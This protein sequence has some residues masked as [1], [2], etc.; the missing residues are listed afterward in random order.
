MNRIL[1]IILLA[2]SVWVVLGFIRPQF[3]ETEV[4]KGLIEERKQT[5]NDAERVI[6]R[7]DQI[8]ADYASV[9]DEEV[10]R[11]KTLL[12]D[13][14]DG[15]RG[16]LEI[17]VLA[18]AYGLSM[19]NVEVSSQSPVAK[20][21][22]DAQTPVDPSLIGPDGYPIQAYKVAPVKV[23]FMGEYESFLAF[24]TDL[25]QSLRLA[26]LSGLE[27]NARVSPK[28]LTNYT[29]SLSLDFYEYVI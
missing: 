10:A 12:P 26:D 17:F 3:A 25:E 20:G 16:V 8:M 14:A 19:E 21:S 9:S 18:H 2:S 1:P 29:Y 5:L 22:A 24:L 6:E 27:I 11:L 23:S 28:E 15:V 4:T 13:R 7:R